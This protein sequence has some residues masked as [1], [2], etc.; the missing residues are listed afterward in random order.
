MAVLQYS[1]FPFGLRNAGLYA[2]TTEPA[3]YAAKTDVARIQN[4]E[5]AEEADSVD[6]SAQD[7]VM[8]THQFADRLTGNFQQGGM[9]IDTLVVLTGGTVATT[10][11]TPNRVTT[12]SRKGTD[13]KKYHKLIGQSYA[14]DAG[15]IHMIAYK[16][17]MSSGPTYA[18]NQGE[19]M[20]VSGD[21][22]YVFN[23]ETPSKL[24]DIVAHETITAIPA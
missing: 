21:M 22:L 1:E 19:F 23:G 14:D 16:G 17:K 9:N 11:V 8:A 10:G 15:D 24:Y 2:L 5:L 12:F 18:Q 7:V 13:A 6:L 20:A 3:T 4:I